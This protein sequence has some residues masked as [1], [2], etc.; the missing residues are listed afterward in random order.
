MPNNLIDGNKMPTPLH[1]H[2]TA[3]NPLPN[4][5]TSLTTNGNKGYDRYGRTLPPKL[6]AELFQKLPFDLDLAADDINH[7]F[8]PAH[9]PFYP[10]LQEPRYLTVL[11]DTHKN[12]K[13]ALTL[14]QK[15]FLLHPN[16]NNDIQKSQ[17]DTLPTLMSWARNL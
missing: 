7:V 14:T 11:D 6:T 17:T 16:W 1:K 5:T 15:G 12:M 10:H 3:T 2:V 13:Q 9:L 4:R 8:T